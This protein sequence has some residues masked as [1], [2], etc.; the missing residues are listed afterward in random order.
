L[1]LLLHPVLLHLRL[2]VNCP[3]A[4]GQ[5][6]SPPPPPPDI[7]KYCTLCYGILHKKTHNLIYF[8][9][10]FTSNFDYVGKNNGK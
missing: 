4:P 2:A 3:E 7:L 1:V 8:V 9:F 5:E 10:V 6:F